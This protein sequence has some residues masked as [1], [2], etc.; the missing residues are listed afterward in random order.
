MNKKQR[1][2]LAFFVPVII[3]FIALTIAN[4]VG[5]T[6]VTEILSKDDPWY[7]YGIRTHISY[8]NNP[9]DWQKTWYVWLIFLIFCCIFEYKIFADKKIIINKNDKNNFI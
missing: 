7:K 2:V 4:S 5:V 6:S 3:L 8:I 1:L 9:F